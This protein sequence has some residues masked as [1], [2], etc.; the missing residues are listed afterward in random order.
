MSIM[1]DK[2]HDLLKLI[3][4]KMEIKTEADERDEGVVITDEQRG[5]DGRSGWS[6]DVITKQLLTQ[7]QVVT[8]W[9]KETKKWP[10]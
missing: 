9:S 6:S 3:V 5:G 10:T 4:Q 1:L 7:S 2:Q 8:H